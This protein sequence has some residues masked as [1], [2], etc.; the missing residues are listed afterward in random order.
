MRSARSAS[1]GRLP[2]AAQGAD[3]YDPAIPPEQHD[4]FT[5]YKRNSG[6]TIN[7]FYEKLLLLADRMNTGMPGRTG[8]ERHALM[9]EFLVVSTGMG[10]PLRS[11][12]L[13]SIATERWPTP[14]RPISRLGRR[15][16]ALWP[17]E[18]SEDRFYALAVGRLG[19][20]RNCWS[21]S[22]QSVDRSR[23]RA[24]GSRLRATAAQVTAIEP[25]VSVVRQYRG[26][27]PIAVA[28]GATRPI[29]DEILRH[30]GLTGWFDAM[31]S[32]EE[33]THHKPAPDIFLEAARRERRSERLSGLRGHGPG[34][35]RPP[36]RNGVC[37]RSHCFHTPPS[38]SLTAGEG[39]YILFSTGSTNRAK[40]T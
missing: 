3:V 19:I 22:R 1:P 38:D 6:P 14:C 29:L 21:R 5:A 16:R 33:V 15:H 31:V 12:P 18:L 36:R 28:T 11:T 40:M 34:I 27:L 4:S 2:T 17:I 32:S 30:I 9:E 39:A 13:S 24:K 8:R 25:V 26:R 20:S 23:L 35:E 10:G 7:H 37:R